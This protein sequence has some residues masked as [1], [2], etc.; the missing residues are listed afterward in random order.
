MCVVYVFVS[1]SAHL[2]C[3]VAFMPNQ[4]VKSFHNKIFSHAFLKILL[5]Q[6]SKLFYKLNALLDDFSLK[7]FASF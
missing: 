2:C 5:L 4:M 1:A 7:I 3:S 6:Y